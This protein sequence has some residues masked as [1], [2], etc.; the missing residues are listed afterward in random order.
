M[1]GRAGTKC[2]IQSPILAFLQCE[3]HPSAKGELLGFN[4][5]WRPC[6]ALRLANA[7][8]LLFEHCGQ[9]PLL[10]PLFFNQRLSEDSEFFDRAVHAQ[11]TSVKEP[12]MYLKHS[13]WSMVWPLTSLMTNSAST[14][15]MPKM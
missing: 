7:K 10:F 12:L 14:R 5:H 8:A 13:P 4:G 11:R 9:P 3:L 1:N 15:A 6:K 2:V